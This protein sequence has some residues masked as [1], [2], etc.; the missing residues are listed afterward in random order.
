MGADGT[1]ASAWSGCLAGLPTGPYT[2]RIINAT[3][4]GAG[5]MVGLNTFYLY[6]GPIQKAIDDPSFFVRQQYIDFLGREPDESGWQAWI[7]YI[8]Q[9]GTDAVCLN[10]HRVVTSSGFINSSEFRQRVGGAFNP[11]YP[12][13]GDTAYN[14]EFVRQ[15]YLTYLNRTPG[16]GEDGGWLNYLFSTG[17]YEGVIGG[18]IQSSEYRTRFDPPPPECAPSDEEIYNCEQTGNGSYWDWGTCNCEYR[19]Y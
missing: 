2:V 1:W 10:Q 3:A 15:C 14:R 7:G 8:T 16:L 13:A 18:F 4:D 6:G 17:D 5:Q 9:C 19:Y 12:G 11:A